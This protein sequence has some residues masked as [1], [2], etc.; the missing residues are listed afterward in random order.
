MTPFSQA[1]SNWLGVKFPMHV[2]KFRVVSD[3]KAYR[4]KESPFAWG[5]YKGKIPES[6]DIFMEVSKDRWEYVTDVQSHI[7][8]LNAEQKMEIGLNR[9]KNNLEKEYGG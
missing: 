1:I 6:A 4:V 2:G 3:T 8:Q 7:S 5:Q 9:I